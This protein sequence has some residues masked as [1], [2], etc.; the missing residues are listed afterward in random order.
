M[1]EAESRLRVLSQRCLA[2]SHTC[3]RTEK[4]TWVISDWKIGFNQLVRKDVNFAQTPL[5]LPPR[6]IRGQGWNIYRV[7]F[8]PIASSY[9]HAE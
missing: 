9:F 2:F 7:V 5:P 4:V 1:K 3:T 6:P 8:A